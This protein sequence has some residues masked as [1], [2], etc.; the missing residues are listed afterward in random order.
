MIYIHGGEFGATDDFYGRYYTLNR[1]AEVAKDE[2]KYF[3]ITGGTFHHDDPS[4]WTH[5]GKTFNFVPTTTH[6]V[7]SYQDEN[8]VWKYTVL[9]N[10]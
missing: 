10:K 8:G 5:H 1:K 6:K 2:Y 9:E 7:D 4:N 3:E